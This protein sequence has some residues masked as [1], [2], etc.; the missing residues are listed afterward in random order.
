MSH[1]LTLYAVGLVSVFLLDGV[2]LGLLMRQ[3]YKVQLGPLARMT[4]DSLTPIWP[5]AILV[6]VLIVAGVQAF[7]LPRVSDVNPGWTGFAWGALFGLVTYGLYD[8]T[9]YATLNRWP[10]VLTV[11]DMAWGAMICG[12]AS[13]VLA[14]AD[15]W[16]RQA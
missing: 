9:N 1:A 15:R 8:L 14:V 13:A 5:A 4:G 3:F 10:L 6:Y 12:T 2:W 7:V 11:V 16:L